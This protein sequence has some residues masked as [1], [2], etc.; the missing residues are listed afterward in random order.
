M[1]RL[2]PPVAYECPACKTYLTRTKLWS[3][4]NFGIRRWS[5]GQSSAWWWNSLA[6]LIRCPG[7]TALHWIDDLEMWGEVPRKPAPVGRFMRLLIRITGDRR[8]M[9]ADLAEWDAIPIGLKHA[10]P[11][12]NVDYGDLLAALKALGDSNS[13][14]EIYI[15]RRIWWLTNDP[16]RLREDDT[17]IAD[18]PVV[19]DNFAQENKLRLLDLFECTESNFVEQG[20][21]LRQLGRFDE[22]I[23]CLK[24]VKPDGFSEVTASRIQ[25]WAQ[26]GETTLM[27]L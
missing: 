20:E 21:L 8:G 13:E 16:Q 26:E 10:R 9:L 27:L 5:D 11:A 12:V 7:C 1:T 14:R 18:I 2:S 19:P 25:T 17:R 15:R 6:P 4:N 22:A 24:S 3:F 23:R